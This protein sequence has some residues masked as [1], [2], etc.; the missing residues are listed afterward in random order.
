MRKLSI[1]LILCLLLGCLLACNDKGTPAS[2]TTGAGESKV[3]TQAPAEDN[4][5]PTEAVTKAPETPQDKW[6]QRY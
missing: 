4:E 5:T 6:T 2:T 3:T 1:V